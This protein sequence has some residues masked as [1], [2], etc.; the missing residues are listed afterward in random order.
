MITVRSVTVT[1]TR[2]DLTGVTTTRVEQMG[3][4]DRSRT[5]A[6]EM[7][8]RDYDNETLERIGQLVDCTARRWMC[9]LARNHQLLF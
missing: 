2:D 5:L 7:T 8:N 3:T 4:G 9:K 1:V 6:V